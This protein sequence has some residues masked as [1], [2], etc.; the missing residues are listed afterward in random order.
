MEATP[1]NR[2]EPEVSFEAVTTQH[3]SSSP[4]L[5]FTAW[6]SF[7]L[8]PRYRDGSFG[9]RSQASFNTGSADAV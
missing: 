2:H 5:S 6:L 3:V 1:H 9:L 4:R 7:C 8:Q